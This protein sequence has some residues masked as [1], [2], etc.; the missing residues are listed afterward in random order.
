MHWKHSQH[1]LVHVILANC[2]TVDEAYRVLCEL[3]EDRLFSIESSLAES[4]RAQSK[5]IAAK[6]V[7]KDSD[8]SKSNKILS[9]CFIDETLARNK[10][11]Q[12]CL[13]EAR[14]EL[15]FIREIKDKLEP[16]R[17]YIELP[18]H[19]AHQACQSEEY[20]Y[21]LFWKAYNFICST[22]TIPHDHWM[23]LKMH[24]NSSSLVP[25]VINMTNGLDTQEAITSFKLKTKQELFSS[26][27]CS[28]LFDT[29]DLCLDYKGG[30]CYEPKISGLIGPGDG[31]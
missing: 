10:L 8:E 20:M 6:L 27:S 12:P 30:V 25:L 24:P 16:Y 18:D 2:H 5:V 13:D 14:R 4:K 23:L 15:A 31:N 21:D 7:L 11:A 29:N 3:E 1:Q 19:Q 9:E 28:N 17:K 26:F 22:G